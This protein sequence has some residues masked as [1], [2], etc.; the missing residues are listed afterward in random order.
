MNEM[1]EAIKEFLVESYENLAQLDS[2]LVALEKAP[3]DRAILGRIFRTL[4]TIKGSCAFLGFKRLQSVAH[5]GEN[6]LGK[7][8]DGVR[9]VSQ[10]TTSVLLAT[11]D[12]IR[13][14]LSTIE[15]QGNDGDRDYSKLIET[16][17]QLAAGHGPAAAA[18]L[19][20]AEQA[21]TASIPPSSPA[22]AEPKPVSPPTP[23]SRSDKEETPQSAKET[24]GPTVYDTTIRLDVSLLDK[25]MALVTELVLSRNQIVQHGSQ[26]DSSLLGGASFVSACRQLNLIT[27]ELQEQVMKTRL[28]PIA[29]IWSRFP[30]MVRDVAVECGKQVTIEMEGSET[31]L[32]KTIIEAIRDPLTHL[33]RNAVDHGIETPAD[34]KAAGKPAQGRLWLRAG[35]E[36]GQVNIEVSDDGGGIDTK[37]IRR[38]AV[39]RGIASSDQAAIM[40]EQT[41]L[42]LIFLP[43]FST[44]NKVTAVSGRGVGMD[45]VKINIEKIGGTVDISSKVGQGTSVKMRIPLTLAIIKALVVTTAGDRYAIPQVSIVELVR[46]ARD[47]SP[48]SIE[49][50]QGVPVYRFRGKLLPVVHL[51][52][53]LNVDKGT[54]Q[55]TDTIDAL[56]NS[57]AVNLAILQAGDRMFGLSV[58]QINDSQEIVVKPLWNKLKGIACFAG[59][60]IM[61]D[62]RVALILD[63]FGLAQQAHVVPKL[64][65]RELAEAKAAAT[66]APEDRLG[67]VL[68]ED[69]R[70]SRMAIPLDKVARLEKFHRNEIE[71]LGDQY[72]VQYRGEILRLLDVASLLANEH[73][74]TGPAMSEGDEDGSLQAVVYSHGGR[75][76]GL[77]VDHILDISEQALTV[78]SRGTRDNVLFSTVIQ[79]HVTEFLDVEGLIHAGDPTFFPTAQA[80]KAEV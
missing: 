40:G 70:H 79:Q 31:E 41:L 51:N 42:N 13:E 39:E 11:V 20:V 67:F 69:R 12:A 62:G 53:I 73:T 58:D 47:K 6:L 17:T 19:P 55:A 7:L 71:R 38:R 36:G 24:G 60:T 54:T 3:G 30:R 78:K 72:V 48:K 46:L 65:E 26:V 45:V 64:R 44:A 4:H 77:V 5:V 29:N 14:M 16:L 2:D 43:G 22:I 49:R 28:Q 35:H 59:A 9:T 23:A 56:R 76:V 63:V 37:R 61:G 27:S 50:I 8:R 33:V 1:Q 52:R 74:S 66:A 10:H 68:I 57:E 25:L 34:R 80:A 75:S 18:K 15:S 21:E 32:D